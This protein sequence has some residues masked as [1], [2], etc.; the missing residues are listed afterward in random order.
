M[1]LA[2]QA[3]I[4]LKA[5]YGSA[6]GGGF[7]LAQS[8]LGAQAH[9]EG[10][11][12]SWTSR[13]DYA[14]ALSGDLAA[15]GA[16][17]GVLDP[18][19]KPTNFEGAAMAGMLDGSSEPGGPGKISELAHI[20]DGIDSPYA[21]YWHDRYEN[22]DRGLNSEY[23]LGRASLEKMISHQSIFDVMPDIP[24]LIQVAFKGPALDSP[25][26]TDNSIRDNSLRPTEFPIETVAYAEKFT[27][28]VG[29]GSLGWVRTAN[30]NYSVPGQAKQNKK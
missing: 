19:P 14:N 9:F 26:G 18:G 5:G 7:G 24:A 1:N 30:D 29:D 10:E 6:I 13:N 20:A 27:E 8:R 3:E 22:A 4:A 17:A 21:K 11:N 23:G 16:G 28:N 25:S 15:M 12:Q 2:A